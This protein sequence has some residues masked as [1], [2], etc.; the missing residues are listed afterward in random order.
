[1]GRALLS[2]LPVLFWLGLTVYT[3][4]DM[5]NTD[6]SRI[7]GLHRSGWIIVAILFPLVGASLWFIVGKERPPRRSSSFG[8]APRGA[9][10][11]DD[12]AR[13]LNQLDR[14]IDREERLRQ[15]EEKFKELDGDDP[16]QPKA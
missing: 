5:I 12:D 3:V 6:D 9:L 8:P 1:M 16:E 4:V 15:L 7:R 2:I 11:P 13:F 10:G 14:E